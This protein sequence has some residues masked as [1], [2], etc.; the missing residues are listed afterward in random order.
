V[1]AIDDPALMD[2]LAEK[3]IGIECCLTSN[4]QTSTVASYAAHPLRHFL[5]RGLLATINTDDPGISD[6]TLDYEFGIAAPQAGLTA[7][8]VALAQK[9]A[10]RIAWGQHLS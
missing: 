1:R 7:D 3:S 9:N 6:I 10:A 5:D 8:H 4:I 2:E